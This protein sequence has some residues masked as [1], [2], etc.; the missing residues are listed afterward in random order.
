[1]SDAESE[2]D[3]RTA[4]GGGREKTG[5]TAMSDE[6]L[7]AVAEQVVRFLAQSKE[8]SSSDA[9]FDRLNIFVYDCI[10]PLFGA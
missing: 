2:G 4:A 8:P 9:G 10:T 7:K 5:E 3:S 6:S 1:M